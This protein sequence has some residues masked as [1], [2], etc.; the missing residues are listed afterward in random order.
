[1]EVYVTSKKPYLKVE[2]GSLWLVFG[3]AVRRAGRPQKA[4]TVLAISP[5]SVS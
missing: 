2:L 3:T 4:T 1:L 5:S